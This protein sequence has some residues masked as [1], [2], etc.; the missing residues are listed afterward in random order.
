MAVVYCRASVSRVLTVISLALGFCVTAESAPKYKVLH[1]FTGTD[2]SGP[3]GGVAFGLRGELYGTT[4]GGGV[5]KCGL[6]NCGVVFQLAPHGNGK[7][8]ETVLYSF[9]GGSGDGSDPQGGVSFDAAGS[10]YGTTYGGGT[11]NYGT[12]FELMPISGGWQESALYSFGTQ[13]GD[14]GQPTSGLVVGQS[15]NLYGTAQNGGSYD[16]GTV[17]ELTPGSGGWNEAVIYE[18]GAKKGDGVRPYASLIQDTGGNFYGATLGGGN[19]CGSSSCG[20]VFELT[21]LAGGGWKETVLHRFNNNGTD[22]ITP[23]S[24]ALFMDGSGSLYGTTESGGCCGGVVYKLT[25]RSGGRWKETILYDFK[26][27]AS[28]WLPGAGVVMDKSGNLYGTTDGGGNS[29]GCGVIYKLAPQPKGKWKY[30]VLYTFS[31]GNDGCI[32]AGNL[33]LDKKGN[34][35]GGTVL[36]GTTGNGVIFELTP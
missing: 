22:G 7:W 25:P 8:T 26:M 19:Q 3:Y 31:G 11:F 6:Y 36:G 15:G 18:F 17:F 29:S 20:T 35:Y 27:G 32:P 2:G 34:L 13:N 24:G 21:P 10:L 33:V 5:G 12:A 16:G 23:G 28:G 14:G 9:Q 30:T 4:V 1:S